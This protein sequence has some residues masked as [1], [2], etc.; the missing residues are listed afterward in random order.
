MKQS[1]VLVQ[2]GVRVHRAPQGRQGGPHVARRRRLC[3][4]GP[5]GQPH[6]SGSVPGL[7]SARQ[8]PSAPRAHCCV[9][10]DVF[11]RPALRPGRCILPR[12]LGDSDSVRVDSLLGL[13]PYEC[14]DTSWGVPGPGPP[15]AESQ[16]PSFCQGP[17]PVR[18]RALVPPNTSR[19]RLGGHSPHGGHCGTAAG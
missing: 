17:G 19:A 2:W 1:R 18:S 8:A 10:G 3:S 13:P 12:P 14:L 15:P 7:H 4:G 5:P 9:T 11:A 16:L 6:P